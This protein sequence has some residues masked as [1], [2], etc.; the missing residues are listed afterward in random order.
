VAARE[1]TFKV[2]EQAIAAVGALAADLR[3]SLDK[4]TRPLTTSHCHPRLSTTTSARDTP[5][6]GCLLTMYILPFHRVC[7]LSIAGVAEDA[8]V[9]AAHGRGGRRAPGPPRAPLRAHVA[10]APTP[11]QYT[12]TPYYH[13]ATLPHGAS[14][15]RV[16]TSH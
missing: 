3:R 1:E 5:L 12:I 6:S 8:P 16:P 7:I 2:E 4:V 11:T 9:G 15:H 14:A 13:A 10:G